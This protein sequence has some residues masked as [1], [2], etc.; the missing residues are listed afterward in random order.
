M[1]GGGL[2]SVQASA[3]TSN[4]PD[5]SLAN[6]IATKFNLKKEDVQTVISD[7]HKEEHSQHQADRQKHTEERLTQAVKDGKITEEQKTKILEYLKTQQSFFEG[8][9]DKTDEERHKAMETH[10][11]E[12]KKW[13]SDNGIDLKYVMG[14]GPGMGRGPHG[15]PDHDRQSN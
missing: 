5:D 14:G 15:G 8:L 13:A 3:A 4:N 10:K 9:K 11:E 7:F 12:V 6:K 1:L 2:Y